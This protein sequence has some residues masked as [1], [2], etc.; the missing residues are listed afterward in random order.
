MDGGVGMKKILDFLE[1]HLNAV[2]FITLFMSM[3][4]QVFMRY[5][6]DMPSPF[7]HELMMYTFVWTVYLSSALAHRYRSHIRF[8]IIYDML[9]KKVRIAIDL[10]FD[11]FV[12]FLLGFSFVPVLKELISYGFIESHILK[13]SWT[14]LYMVFPIFMV[15][16]LYHNAK[17][18]YQEIRALLKGE[19]IPE[20]EKPWD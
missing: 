2:I 8:N 13:I 11:L 16:V 17:F 9:P 15:L 18:V 3:V 12:S 4:V 10:V 6:L 14:Y 20:E 5:V 1:L 7:L 19:D